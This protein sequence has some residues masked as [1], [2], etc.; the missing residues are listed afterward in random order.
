[1]A[2]VLEYASLFVR[3]GTLEASYPG[4]FDAFWADC[5]SAS[6]VADDQL[7]RVGA[8]SSRDLGLIAADVRRRAPAI[9]DHEIAIATRE[10][11]TRRWLSIGEIE[12]TMC[13]WLV[14]TEPGA[15]FAACTGEMLMQ[16]DDALQAAELASRI[17]ALR[18][19]GERALVVRGEAA[20]EL[21][22]WEDAPVVSVTSCFGRVA[23]FG[24][25]A[26]LRDELVAE[27]VRAGWRRAPRR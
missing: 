13:V 11:S 24:P 7:A 14:D 4:G 1:M 12:N 6:F 20:V 2:I 16:G 8:M 23:G 27:L 21:D 19:L 22:L 10:Q 25:D 9:A 3:R 26:S 15:Q 17:G 5:R 18:P